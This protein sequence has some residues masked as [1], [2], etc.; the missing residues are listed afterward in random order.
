MNLEKKLKDY[1]QS[2]KIIPN[3][4]K[5]TETIRKSIDAY[6]SVEQERL[7]TYW[8]FLWIQLRLIRKRWWSFQILL[9]ILLW[10]ALRTSGTASAKNIKGCCF[11]VYYFDYPGIME[12][13]NLSV[14]G[15]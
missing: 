8:E 1:N 10:A 15:N 12:K 3:E 13:S 5:V 7:L 14:N 11:P 2:R 4:K 6:C 9:L